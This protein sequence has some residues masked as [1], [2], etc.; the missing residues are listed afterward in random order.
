MAFLSGSQSLRC[1]AIF[2]VGRLRSVAISLHY[3]RSRLSYFLRGRIMGRRG[4]GRSRKEKTFSF[5]F[6]VKTQPFSFRQ[7]WDL[8]AYIFLGTQMAI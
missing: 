5:L 8:L 6:N 3:P 2:N 4:G 1:L 7:L